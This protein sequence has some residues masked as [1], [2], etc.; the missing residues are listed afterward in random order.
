LGMMIPGWFSGRAEEALGYAGFFSWIMIST[1]PSFL[2]ATLVY[3]QVDPGFGR[4]ER[5]A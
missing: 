1:I 4:R 2:V 3:F 5:A